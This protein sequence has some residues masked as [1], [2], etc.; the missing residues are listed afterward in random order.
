MPDKHPQPTLHIFATETFLTGT[1]IDPRM[2]KLMRVLQT[3]P[4]NRF[5]LV[6][7]A[8]N[9]GKRTMLRLRP[10]ATKATYNLLPLPGPTVRR[11]EKVGRVLLPTSDRQHVYL[12]FAYYDDLTETWGPNPPSLRAETAARWNH[13]WVL[14]NPG[15]L[16]QAMRDAHTDCEHTNLIGPNYPTDDTKADEVYWPWQIAA[17]A[18][19]ITYHTIAKYYADYGLEASE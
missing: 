9:V 13:D 5:A 8:P 4:N 18:A 10:G 19:G 1:S 2:L 14:P 16:R 11:Q 17:S 12:T 7:S 15:M 6:T 3:E